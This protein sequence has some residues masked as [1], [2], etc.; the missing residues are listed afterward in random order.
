MVFQIFI[1]DIIDEIADN[2]GNNNDIIDAILTFIET[3]LYEILENEDYICLVSYDA[4]NTNFNDVK[5]G[6]SL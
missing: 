3:K 6:Y 2:G 5:V 1:D 4:N